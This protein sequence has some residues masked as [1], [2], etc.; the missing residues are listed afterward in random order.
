VVAA[1]AER[2]RERRLLRTQWAMVTVTGLPGIAAVIDLI[3]TFTTV[4]QAQDT[5]RVTE[6]G[7]ITDRYNNAVTNLGSATIDTRLGGICAL[8]RIMADSARDQ[9]TVSRVLSA[10]VRVHP[11]SPE[12][13]DPVPLTRGY[14]VHSASQLMAATSRTF[15]QPEGIVIWFWGPACRS[16]G[17]L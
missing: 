1:A 17:Q 16:C 10:F 3:F 13:K 8:Q 2:D 5:L 4:Q 11:L 14:R 9:P 6:Q 7:Q 15:Q 12:T